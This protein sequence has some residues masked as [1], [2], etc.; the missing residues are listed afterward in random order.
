MDTRTSIL[1]VAEKLVKTRGANGMSYDDISA[2]VGIRKASIHYHFKTKGDLL[3]ALVERYTDRFLVAAD[4]IARARVNGAKKLERFAG[5][6]VAPLKESGNEAIC[7]CGMMASDIGTLDAVSRSRVGR[8]YREGMGRLTAI[9]EEGR[10]DGSLSFEGDAD[11]TA[12]LVFSLLEGAMMSV[13]V[14]GGVPSFRKTLSQL[15][16]LLGAS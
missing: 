10:N 11:Q 12:G 14:E 5:L 16:R 13:R 15:Y 3:A 7:L 8:F 2:E 1:D 9:L 6:F 4:D